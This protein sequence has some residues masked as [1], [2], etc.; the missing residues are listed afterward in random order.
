MVGVSG[1]NARFHAE[2]GIIPENAPVTTLHQNME[3]PIVLVMLPKQDLVTKTLVQVSEF[4][5]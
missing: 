5:A 2:M 3:A 1:A 4:Y